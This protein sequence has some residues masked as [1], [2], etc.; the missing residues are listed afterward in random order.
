[1]HD[2][3]MC[4]LVRLG[5]GEKIIFD[6]IL[7]SIEKDKNMQNDR[8]FSSQVVRVRK[9]V[10]MKDL[11]IYKDR[12]NDSES[13]ENMFCK[14]LNEFLENMF[15][16]INDKNGL[17]A[18]YAVQGY[19]TF[20]DS[21][22]MIFQTNVDLFRMI[23]ATI[24]EWSR[25]QMNKERE[26]YSKVS[27]DTYKSDYTEFLIKAKIVDFQTFVETQIRYDLQTKLF[28]EYD[29]LI[30]KTGKKIGLKKVNDMIVLAGS[31]GIRFCQGKNGKN[32]YD[33]VINY[34]RKEAI[35]AIYQS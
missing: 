10:L 11:H 31:L 17:I 34:L 35:S 23:L 6:A 18:G 29:L 16:S 21:P 27:S 28:V 12:M 8:D 13:A 19:K 9:D 15:F 7:D 26:E 14:V 25:C 33:D 30:K 20:R 32:N 5:Y 3:I 2:E 1:M 4:K 22:V 24:N